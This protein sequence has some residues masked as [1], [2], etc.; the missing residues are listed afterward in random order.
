MPS[1]WKKEIF[2][3]MSSEICL[4]GSRRVITKGS[5]GATNPICR[6]IDFENFRPTQL[7]K[8]LFSTDA[9][10]SVRPSLWMRCAFDGLTLLAGARSL[11]LSTSLH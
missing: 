8:I 10:P 9:F 5:G 11:S 4:T 3:C 2:F 7:G 6:L 1:S